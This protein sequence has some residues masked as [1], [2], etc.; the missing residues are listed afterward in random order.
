MAPTLIVDESG[1]HVPLTTM[2]PGLVGGPTATPTEDVEV[3]PLPH[4][5][6][7]VLGLNRLSVGPNTEHESQGGSTD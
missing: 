4:H 7:D 1:E 2:F 3:V 6:M 5:E